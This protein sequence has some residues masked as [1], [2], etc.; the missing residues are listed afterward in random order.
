MQMY[1]AALVALLIGAAMGTLICWMLLKSQLT[2]AELRGRAGGDVER[3][4]LAEKLSRSVEESALIARLRASD[5]ATISD[6]RSVLESARLE[7]AQFEERATRVPQLEEVVTRLRSDGE[8]LNQQASNL[9]EQSGRLSS[10]LESQARQIAELNVRE[11]Q[12]AAEH[13]LMVSEREETVA[14]LRGEIDSQAAQ[15]ADLREEKGRRVT[16][17]ESLAKKVMELTQAS[18]LLS[19]ERDSFVRAAANNQSAVATLTSELKAERAQGA[20]KLA[21]LEQAKESLTHQFKVLAEAILDE[22]TKK[23]TEQNQS[24]L[25]QLLTPLRERMIEFSAKVE[26]IHNKGTEQQATLRAELGQLKELN[27][28]MTAE[29]HELAVALKGDAKKRGNWGELVLGNVLERS[30]LREG[31]DF[32]KEVNFTTE[33]GRRRPDVIIYLPQNKHLVIDAKV[34]LNA[35]TR[36]VN[37]EDEVVRQ[38]SLSE[39]VAAVAARIRELSDRNYFELP[40]VNSPEMVFMFIPIES[41]FVEAL[42]ADEGLFERAIEKNVLVATPTTLLTSLNIVRQLWRFEEQNAHSAELAE[43]AAAIYKKLGTFLASMTDIGEKLDRAKDSYVKA[44]GQFYLGKGNLIQRARDFERLG[45]AIKSSLPEQLVAKAALELEHLP[46]E[47][48]EEV[49]PVSDVSSDG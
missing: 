27:R 6:L 42:R 37:A 24:N 33:E 26:E 22:K 35:Y 41:A 40:G 12:A 11:S 49:G 19:S 47:A 15:I 20:E 25:G 5:E 32:K 18:D 44:I 29:A 14:K 36:Y 2:L 10:L 34:P 31:K 9:R 8:S 46:A 45:V 23:F 1:A 39:H 30:G 21:I 16:E 48:A 7:R 17:A 4:Q 28:Q 38:Q 13:S 3:A 43:S